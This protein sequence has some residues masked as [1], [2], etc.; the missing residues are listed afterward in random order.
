MQPLGEA[1]SANFSHQAHRAM[2]AAARANG[3]TLGPFS[4][5]TVLAYPGRIC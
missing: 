5:I 3:L 4:Y 1:A 2:I